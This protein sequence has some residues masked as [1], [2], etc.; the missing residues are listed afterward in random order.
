MTKKYE[1]IQKVSEIIADPFFTVQVEGLR[2]T[3]KWKSG[4]LSDNKKD[5]ISS[6]LSTC[7][8]NNTFSIISNKSLR[9]LDTLKII[10]K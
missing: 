9:G 6:L 4:F 2:M 5:Q 8:F 10:L 7:G 1:I 3:A